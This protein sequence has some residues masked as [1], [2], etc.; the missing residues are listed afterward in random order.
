[1]TD[2]ID[3]RRA[4]TGPARHYALVPDGIWDGTS[5]SLLAGTAVVVSGA[6]IESVTPVEELQ[7]D[8]RRVDLPGCTVVPGLMDAHA[9]YSAPMG[10]AF[11]AAGITTIRDVGN[12]LQWILDQ[13]AANSDRPDRGPAIVCCGH[14]QDGPEPYWPRMGRAN[15]DAD[16]VRRSVREHIAAGV[17]QIKLYPGLDI[18]MLAAG[19]DEAHRLGKP[20]TA[21]LGSCTVEDAV[22]AGLD[23]IEHL[24]GCHV[25][26]REATEEEDDALIDLL[27]QHQVAVDPTLLVWDRG[28]V[29]LAFR[30]DERRHWAHPAH[31]RYWDSVARRP[32]PAAERLRGQREM[33]YLKRFLLRAHGRGVAVALGTDVPFPRLPPGFSVHVHSQLVVDAKLD[34]VDALQSATSVNAT[35]LGI[36]SRAGRVAAGLAAD[37]LA[38][39]GDPLQDIRDVGNV[40]LVVRSG[41]ILDR[42]ELRRAADASFAETPNDAITNDL[43]DRIESHD[44]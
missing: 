26:W 44:D 11:L 24:A 39:K 9:H 20:A 37:L 10:P 29:D 31:R 33:T 22:A 36:E 4:R 42:T 25:A 27:L 34:P 13:R 3:S 40:E 32:G 41:Q 2:D 12:D 30:H 38:V 23:G 1:M 21:H 6:L 35:V 28:R 16:A 17:D 5:D 15:A 43:L 18:E 8:L 14:L 19:V 7:P